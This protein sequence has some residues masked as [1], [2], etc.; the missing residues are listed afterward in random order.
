MEYYPKTRFDIAPGLYYYIADD[1]IDP[2]SAAA[3][4]NKLPAIEQAQYARYCHNK[5]KNAF[6]CART[7]LREEFQSLWQIPYR[8]ELSFNEY[9]KPYLSRHK[10]FHF[11]ISHSK[12]KVA[13]AFSKYP[14]GIDIER[15]VAYGK[16]HL[17]KLSR[18]VLHPAE[19][20]HLQQLNEEES[21][22]FF[23]KLWT[24]K[25][26]IAK[27]TGTGFAHGN[28]PSLLVHNANHLHDMIVPV[29]EQQIHCYFSVYKT[30]E[31]FLTAVAYLPS[32]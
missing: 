14:V 4:L 32:Q 9:Q 12:G 30:Q 21:R 23:T 19:I 7:V 13:L 6:L 22:Y 18:H 15:L 26:S 2:A 17:L 10:D 28:F 1:A 29:D 16:E 31:T 11:N 24:L 3:L 8:S 25:E 20:A 27:A 5:N